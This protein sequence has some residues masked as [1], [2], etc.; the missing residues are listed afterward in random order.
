[1]QP[2]INLQDISL[3]INNHSL[4]KHISF[5]V[6]SGD[7]LTITGPSGSG[8]STILKLIAGL[9]SRTSG[10]IQFNNQSID[11]Y[12][13]INYRRVV[14]YCFQTPVLFGETVKDNLEFPYIIRKQNF[15]EAH[16]IVSLESVGLPSHY[17]SKS[18]NE[19]SGGEKQRV[20]LIRNLIFLPKV[21]L[22]DE[23]TS[24]LD[25]ESKKIIHTLINHLNDSNKITIIAVTHD[26]SEIKMAD[27]LI[28]IVNGQM[29]E[30]THE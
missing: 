1:M 16:A 2:I 3:E 19:L 29:T 28:E 21:L 24:A 7:F 26:D 12:D 30:V 20:A 17:L 27:Q 9:I 14:S 25:S 8:K 18:I 11:S 5:K 23:I 4:L 15:D 6:N 22:L 10:D 13:P